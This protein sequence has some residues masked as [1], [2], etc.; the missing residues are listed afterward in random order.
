MKCDLCKIRKVI[1]R[2]DS[3]EMNDKGVRLHKKLLKDA[4]LIYHD[5]TYYLCEDCFNKY[6]NF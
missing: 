5:R 6:K 2:L 3:T 1:Y 4:G